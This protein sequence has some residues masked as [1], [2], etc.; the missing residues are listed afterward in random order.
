MELTSKIEILKTEIKNPPIE[1]RNSK[2]VSLKII[3]LGFNTL[4]IIFPAASAKLAYK[5]FTTPRIRARHKKS[6]RILESARLFEFIYGKHILKGYEWGNGE[7]TVLLVHGWESRGTAMRSFVPQLVESG[8][9]VV[10]FDGP[11][12]GNSAGKRTNLPH[13]GGSVNAIINYLGGVYGIVT[14]SFGGA[15]TVF[16]LANINNSISVDK[17]ILIAVPSSMEN[18]SKEFMAMIKAPRSIAKRFNKILESKI[19][20]PLENA[21][22]NQSFAKINVGETLVVH[23]RHDQVVPYSEAMAVFD[24]WEDTTLLVTENLGHFQLLKNPEL[25]GK[26]VGFVKKD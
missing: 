24:S 20:M 15:S 12:H 1:K 5:F 26:V 2:S 23:D 17:L 11:A 6:D 18:L 3:Q 8:F 25:V 19:N 4:G 14:H 10:A 16:S 22:L 7:R 21:N 13:F 9:K